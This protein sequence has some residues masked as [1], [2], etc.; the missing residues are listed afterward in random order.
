MVGIAEEEELFLPRL[1]VSGEGLDDGLGGEPL[2][3]EEGE[4]GHVER[5]PLGLAGPVEERARQRPELLRRRLDPRDGF[6]SLG[7]VGRGLQPGS[8]RGDLGDQRLALLAGRVLAVPLQ[9]RRE[10]RII[11]MR[12]RRLLLLASSAESVGDFRLG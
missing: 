2:V 9:A 6:I 3:D 4:R 5:E 12:G 11:A 1:L 7:V 10:R 8:L